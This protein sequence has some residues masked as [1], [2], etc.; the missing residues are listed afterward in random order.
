MACTVLRRMPSEIAMSRC[1]S[2]GHDAC[3]VL[4]QCGP[5]VACG[6][7]KWSG[8][9]GGSRPLATRTALRWLFATASSRMTLRDCLFANDPSQM[10]LRKRRFAAGTDTRRGRRS[11]RH[12]ARSTPTR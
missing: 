5:D 7:R 9:R 2:C 3:A 11:P 10:T 4:R 12:R 1:D 6:H 8:A